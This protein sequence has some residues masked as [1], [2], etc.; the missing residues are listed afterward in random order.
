MKYCVCCENYHK[1]KL[2]V[3]DSYTG[4]KEEWI[5]YTYCTLN[6]KWVCIV[7]EHFCSHFLRRSEPYEKSKH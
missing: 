7:D 2:L 5:T 1:V 3:R 4:W 6:T